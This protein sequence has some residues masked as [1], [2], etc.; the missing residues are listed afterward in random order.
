MEGTPEAPN[1]RFS[2]RIVNTLERLGVEYQAI[3]VLA[4]LSPLREVTAEISR[5]R[6]FPQLYVR[7]ELV[8]GSDIVERMFLSG[9]LARLLGVAATPASARD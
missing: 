6:S 9:E 1:N 3:D 4:L 8:G 2:L 7:G 5:C